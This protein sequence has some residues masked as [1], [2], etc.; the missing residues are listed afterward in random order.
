MSGTI[1]VYVPACFI[2]P[3]PCDPRGPRENRTLRPHDCERCGRHMKW[4]D[5]ECGCTA[6]DPWL[7]R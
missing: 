1:K 4:D 3:E 7:H 2:V 5:Q 6:S